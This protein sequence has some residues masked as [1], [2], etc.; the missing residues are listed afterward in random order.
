MKE[1]LCNIE[2]W[3]HLKHY[4]EPR[5]FFTFSSACIVILS[6]SLKQKSSFEIC[7]SVFFYTLYDAD[8]IKIKGEL[9]PDKLFKTSASVSYSKVYFVE[10]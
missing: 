4:T 10:P 1:S 7:S 5:F 9:S 2:N 3:L 8:K 6:R